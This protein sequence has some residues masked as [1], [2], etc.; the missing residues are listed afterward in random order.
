MK[1]KAQRRL[2]G[3]AARADT[4]GETIEVDW[5]GGQRKQLWGFSRTALW[6]TPRVPPVGLRY[7]L[8]CDPEGQLRMEVF[9]CTDLDATPAQLPQCVVRRWSVEVTCEEA[10]AHLGLETQRPW[11]DHT[12]ARTTPVRSGPCSRW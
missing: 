7:V 8:A 1:G 2:Q 10:R 3:W 5:Y 9:C 4:P 11:S 12:I 6:Y